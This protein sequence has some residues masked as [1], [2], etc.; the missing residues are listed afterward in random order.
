MTAHEDGAAL[1][2]RYVAAFEAGDA[3]AA[4]ALFA[5]DAVIEDPVG[6]PPICGIDA[7]RAFYRAAMATGAKL[8][9]QGPVRVC[10]DRVVFPFAVSLDWQGA[11]QVIDVIDV[12][13]LAPDGRIAEMRAFFGPANMRTVQ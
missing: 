9:L 7:I 12:F 2:A 3:D 4:A 1:V 13:R 6:S 11:R 8:S 5:E 10:T